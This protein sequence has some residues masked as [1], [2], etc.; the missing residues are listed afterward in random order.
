MPSDNQSTFVSSRRATLRQVAQEARASKTSVSRYFGGAREQL[1]PDLQKRIAQAAAQLNY[2]PNL[3]ARS[4]K[5]GRTGLIGMLV[6]DIR[7]PFSVAAMHGVEQAAREQGFSLMVCNTNND[8]LL[9]QVHLTQLTSYGIEGLVVNAS[10]QAS[11]E[12]IDLATNGFPIVLLDRQLP[13]IEADMVGLDNDAAIDI[14]IAHLREAGYRDVLYLSE[15]INHTSSRQER[16]SRLT[17]QLAA[18]E[19]T[20]NGH[21][22]M[23]SLSDDLASLSPVIEQFMSTAN[24]PAILCGNGNMTLM[25]ARCLKQLKLDLG[26]IGLLGIDELEW[27]S[28]L[29]PGITTL[30]QPTEEIGRRAFACLLERNREAYVGQ[31]RH[32]RYHPTLIKRGSTSCPDFHAT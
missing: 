18:H 5:G 4:L 28:L 16:L 15:P 26:S 29:T 13:G 23:L 27:C 11:Q 1:S 12:L 31:S 2:R 9:E 10:G 30:A 25:A 8:P 3:I 6:A 19:G 21:T 32:I 24:R 14:A 17:Y 22:F 7:T 20:L